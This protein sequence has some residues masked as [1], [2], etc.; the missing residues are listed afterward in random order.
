MDCQQLAGSVSPARLALALREAGE[1]A[2]SLAAA[3]GIYSGATAP[4]SEPKKRLIADLRS[5]RTSAG[6]ALAQRVLNGEFDD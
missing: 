1:I 5:L 2:M 6:L 3:R 4:L